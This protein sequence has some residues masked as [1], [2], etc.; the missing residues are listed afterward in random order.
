MRMG[1]GIMFNLDKSN[2]NKYF[3][4]FLSIKRMLCGHPLP[5]ARKPKSVSGAFY[6]RDLIHILSGLVC[7]VMGYSGEHPKMARDLR[8]QNRREQNLNE[9]SFLSFPC[10]IFSGQFFQEKKWKGKEKIKL[11]C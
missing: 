3:L 4:V 9:L 2:D 11:G 7:F 1:G 6:R 10:I 5:L 8:T